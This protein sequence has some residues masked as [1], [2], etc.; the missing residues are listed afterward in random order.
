MNI[1][2]HDKRIEKTMVPLD[3]ETPVTSR[4]TKREIIRRQIQESRCDE[5][6][7]ENASLL[8][9]FAT[10]VEN[11]FYPEKDVMIQVAKSF[12]SVLEATTHIYDADPPEHWWPDSTKTKAGET[13]KAFVNAFSM[14]KRR[15][16]AKAEYEFN[17]LAMRIASIR[18]LK[19]E[20][21]RWDALGNALLELR[22]KEK[23]CFIDEETHRLLNSRQLKENLDFDEEWLACYEE[24]KKTA[25]TAIPE[26]TKGEMTAK[27]E[28]YKK[29]LNKMPLCEK[30]WGYPSGTREFEA[31]YMSWFDAYSSADDEP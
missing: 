27:Y 12:R 15:D 28:L 21:S 1:D 13:G 24:A 20:L 10:A 3:G 31:V 7:Q 26:V 17:E 16:S 2:E 23:E 6:P 29:R 14:H 25:E 18:H 22:C 4:A 5:N 11:G 30:H 9:A 8:Y 19:P